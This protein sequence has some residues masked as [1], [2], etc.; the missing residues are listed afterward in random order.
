MLTEERLI[1]IMDQLREKSFVSIKDLMET[2]DVSRSSIMRDLQE[3][4]EQHLIRRV[5]GGASI[6]DTSTLLTRYNEPAVMFKE[7][8]YKEAK[9]MICQNALKVIKDGDC[10]F[11]DSG[12]TPLG[13]IEGLRYRDI[14][15]VTPNTYLLQ[16]L[17]LDFKGQIYLL[18]GEF[19]KKYDTSYGSMT[20]DL[21]EHFH[22]DACFMTA[23]G[24]DLESQEVMA[25]DLNVAGIKKAVLKRSEKAYLMADHSKL[26]TKGF[27]T[28]ANLSQFTNVFLDTFPQGKPM[29]QNFVV[30][31]ENNL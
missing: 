4:E 10:I 31:E 29:P 15:M 19:S 28:W 23:N 9:K 1:R 5:R 25:F 3:L 26:Y 24:V 2:L 17:P 16:K 14:E 22:F 30:S 20:L 18:G 13:L 11:V 6:V 27:C 12:T 8:T 21:I 7:D